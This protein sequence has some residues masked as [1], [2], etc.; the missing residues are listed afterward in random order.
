M[1][2]EVARRHKDIPLLLAAGRN[3]RLQAGIHVGPMV[4]A[5]TPAHFLLDL[6]RAQVALGL[7]V[8]ERDPHH[9]RESQNCL[10]R[11]RQT[12]QQIPPW[13]QGGLPV[14]P[15]QNLTT[16]SARTGRRFALQG[17]SWL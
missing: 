1:G 7:V 10:F 8:G 12:A 3:H 4:G 15:G 14:R 6:G 11:L 2:K 13:R 17:S 9:Q 16:A 5:K